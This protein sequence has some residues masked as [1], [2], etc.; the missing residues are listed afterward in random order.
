LEHETA[1]DEVP[2][3]GNTDLYGGTAGMTVISTAATT[4]NYLNTTEGVVA[5]FNSEDGVE[6]FSFWHS[7]QRT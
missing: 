7:L 1:A 2:L 3:A 4:L 5:D 6:D